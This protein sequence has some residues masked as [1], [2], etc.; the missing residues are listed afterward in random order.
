MKTTVISLG[1]S[2]IV[3]DKIDVSFLKRFRTLIL[4]YVNNGNR[5]IIVC[6]GGSPCRVYQKASAELTKPTDIDKDWIGIMATRLN[7]ELVRVMFKDAAYQKVICNPHEK[8]KTNKKIIVGAG[9]EPG[10]STDTDTVI[11]A[12]QFKAGLVINTTNVDYVYNKDPREFN[13][14]KKIKQISWQEYKRLV[15]GKFLPGMHIPFDPI[16]SRIAMRGRLKV[17]IANGRNIPNLRNILYGKRFIGTVI[18]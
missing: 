5:A 6:G 2:V 15:G 13:D 1:G 16:A 14:A 4:D 17:V 9:Y 7:A 8:I 18:G 12:R 3:P 11:L 10:C